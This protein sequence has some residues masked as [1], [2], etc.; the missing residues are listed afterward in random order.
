MDRLEGRNKGKLAVKPSKPQSEDRPLPW[1]S[2]CLDSS[3]T[4]DR[5]RR[6]D[7]TNR[8]LVVDTVC[9]DTNC[10]HHHS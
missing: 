5:K 2:G 10:Q 6:A 3:F 9:W 7:T 8:K 1:L 4:T